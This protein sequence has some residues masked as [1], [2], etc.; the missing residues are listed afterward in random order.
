MP[1]GPEEGFRGEVAS[2]KGLEGQAGIG[3]A[4]ISGRG[5]RVHMLLKQDIA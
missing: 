3:Q 5:N 4:E 2:D 1:G